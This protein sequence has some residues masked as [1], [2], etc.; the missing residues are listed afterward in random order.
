[1]SLR[2]RPGWNFDGPKF[3]QIQGGQRMNAFN[4]RSSLNLL[5]ITW[6]Q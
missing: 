3:Q 4:L 2:R 5:D 1:M 6:H